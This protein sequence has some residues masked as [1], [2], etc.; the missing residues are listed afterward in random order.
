MF[1]DA[2]SNHF[3]PPGY[4]GNNNGSPE[5]RPEH[6]AAEQK[7]IGHGYGHPRFI[8]TDKHPVVGVT[9]YEAEAC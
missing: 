6:W 9:Y 2:M 5:E 3:E 8:Q 4:M 1:P 7:W